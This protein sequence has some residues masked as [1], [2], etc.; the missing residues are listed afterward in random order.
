MLRVD[1][2][3]VERQ[4]LVVEDVAE[5]LPLGAQVILVVWVGHGLNRE[6]VG[7]RE[8][9]ALE[10]VDLLRVVGQDPDARQP[11]IHEDLSADAVVA[12]VGWKAELQVRVHG[13]QPVLLELVS[14]QLVEQPDA[15]ALL[16]EIEQDAGAFALDHRER[17]IELFPAIAS[18]RVEDVARQAL[19]VD[20]HEYVV[21]APYVPL[22]HR[23]VVLLVHE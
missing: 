3:L 20:P 15:A 11:E 14:A 12:K 23:Q 13:V 7:D 9:V 5:A 22:H 4:A 19:G 16:R 18:K 1:Q 17:R 8:A 6:L 21:A 10:S 2:L